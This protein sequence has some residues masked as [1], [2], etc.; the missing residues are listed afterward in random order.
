MK[1]TLTM[2]ALLGAVT[3]LVQAEVVWTEGLNATT[4]E[5]YTSSKYYYDSGKWDGYNDS[6]MCFAAA[7]SNALAWWQDRV[8]LSGALI[9]PEN[10]PRGEMVWDKIRLE[11]KNLDRGGQTNRV[12]QYYLSGCTGYSTDEQFLTDKGIEFTKTGGYYPHLKGTHEEMNSTVFP[13]E[14]VVQLVDCRAYNSSSTPKE[15]PDGYTSYQ[16]ASALL[17]RLLKDG[18]GGVL[19]TKSD[20]HAMSFYA[21]E[22][23]A[24]GNIIKIWYHDNNSPSDTLK[25]GTVS[26]GTLNK[27]TQLPTMAATVGYGNDITSFSLIRSRDLQFDTYSLTMTGGE[28]DE[29]LFSHFLNLTIDGAADY[30]LKYDLRNAMDD[31]SPVKA[32]DEQGGRITTGD[33]RLKDGKLSLVACEEARRVLDGGGKT[34]GTIRFEGKEGSERVLSVQHTDTIATEINI[35]ALNGNTLEVTAGNTATFGMLSGEG[36]LDKTGSGTAEVTESVSLKGSI[37]VHE[38]KFVLGADASLGNDTVLT[39]EKQGAVESKA[40]TAVT[41]SITD[42]IHIND[43]AML[44]AT[45]LKGGTLKGSGT[46]GAV[47]VDGGTLIVGNSPGHQVYTDMLTVTDGEL[48]FCVA[49]WETPSTAALTGW[50]SESYST[51]DMGGNAF[52]VS[53]EARIFIDL[54]DAAA[55]SLTLG[56]PFSLELVTNMGNSFTADELTMLAG[57]TEFR[58]SDE[59]A[60]AVTFRGTLTQPAFSYKMVGNSLM[61]SVVPEPATVTLSLLALA[62]LAS[63][64]RRK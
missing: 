52:A 49:G 16:G 39:V 23:D 9:I 56:G 21:V 38:G 48:V 10:A 15:Y 31:G 7:A 40:A 5:Q 47:T 37:T 20:P 33:I 46:F 54:N 26:A 45:T 3:P 44:L 32:L 41:L 2:M 22:T 64:R 42:G 61:L 62:G 11:W 18:A 14:S 60:A 51:I 57:I 50:E 19:K 35:N 29:A 53:E 13:E 17:V 24:D 27:S 1:K 25:T 6:Y 36:N 43:G 59:E 55:N 4:A 30:Q 8:E 63:R 28:K 58:L 12:M 34:S